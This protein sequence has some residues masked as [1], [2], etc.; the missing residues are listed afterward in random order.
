LSKSSMYTFGNKGSPIRLTEDEAI[1]RYGAWLSKVGL[2]QWDS[3]S[4]VKFQWGGLSEM[5]D[6]A[7]KAIGRARGLKAVAR[8]MAAVTDD[9]GPYI[10]SHMPK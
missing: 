2:R 7:V 9:M 1:S 6:E 5:S 10:E 3:G 8:A 4:E